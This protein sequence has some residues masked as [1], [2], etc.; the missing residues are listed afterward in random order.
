MSI[1]EIGIWTAMTA[2]F[3]LCHYGLSCRRQRDDTFFDRFYSM[4]HA[5]Y[6]CKLYFDILKIVSLKKE[7]GK[8]EKR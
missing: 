7:I 5:Y 1:V 8:M 4:Y 6:I 3:G 2:F